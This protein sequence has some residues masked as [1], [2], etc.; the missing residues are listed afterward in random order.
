MRAEIPLTLTASSFTLWMKAWRHRSEC[1][2]SR[3]EGD[4]RHY[5]TV[6]ASLCHAVIGRPSQRSPRTIVV[7]PRTL[8]ARRLGVMKAIT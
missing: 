1:R 3:G 6:S 4:T 7:G 5:R 8:I 2:S